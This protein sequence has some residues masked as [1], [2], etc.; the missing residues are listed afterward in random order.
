[1]NHPCWTGSSSRNRVCSTGTRPSATASTP[2][3]PPPRKPARHCSGSG[4]PPHCARPSRAPTRSVRPWPA[5]RPPPCG[6]SPS[7]PTATTWAGASRYG[8][9]RRPPALPQGRHTGFV[10]HPFSRPNPATPA[11]RLKN[12]PTAAAAAVALRPIP[13]LAIQTG[14]AV[15]AAIAAHRAGLARKTASGAEQ[16][17]RPPHSG[18][19]PTP[20]TAAAQRTDADALTRGRFGPRGAGRRA[21]TV[22]A[23]GAASL[24]RR[25]VQPECM[26]R[27]A[28]PSNAAI[29][30]HGRRRRGCTP[31]QGDHT[32]KATRQFP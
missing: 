32:D 25:P 20:Q 12:S 31:W 23:P 11:E 22:G 4:S 26:P 5:P 6:R 8:R 28:P 14:A 15:A 7:S 2:T 30:H 9:P 27:T 24:P 21:G 29:H 13:A 18:R 17:P 10:K 3:P 19:E 16:A 1:M